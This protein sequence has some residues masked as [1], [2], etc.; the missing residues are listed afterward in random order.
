L[1][2]LKKAEHQTFFHHWNHLIVPVAKRTTE[3]R[4]LEFYMRLYFAVLPWLTEDA[5]SVRLVQRKEVLN[6]LLDV[7]IV[8]R[9][10]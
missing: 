9:L 8:A 10:I 6:L 3:F 4:E 5:V 1:G 2:A 7:K